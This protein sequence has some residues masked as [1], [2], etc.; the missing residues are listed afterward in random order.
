M[1][2]ISKELSSSLV[3]LSNPDDDDDDDVVVIGSMLECKSNLIGLAI[4][5]NDDGLD[6][7]ALAVV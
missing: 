1:E 2:I 3:F 5:T 4:F 6:N 7:P